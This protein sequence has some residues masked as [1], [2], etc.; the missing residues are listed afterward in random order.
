LEQHSLGRRA[1]HHIDDGPAFLSSV[2]PSPKYCKWLLET[3]TRAV[4][5]LLHLVMQSYFAWR[6]NGSSRRIRFMMPRT[7]SVAMNVSITRCWGP[8]NP[9]DCN[10]TARPSRP[11]RPNPAVF[12]YVAGC[13][14]WVELPRRTFGSSSVTIQT[15]WAVNKRARR[16]KGG[17]ERVRGAYR[18]HW[19]CEFE[20]EK[21]WTI[22]QGA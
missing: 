18:D 12:I 14:P 19:P 3:D 8:M 15:R 5:R 16:L 21:K 10:P 6:G 22:Q 4:A 11:A 7:V 9:K 2:A 20:V 1:T 17:H 13:L